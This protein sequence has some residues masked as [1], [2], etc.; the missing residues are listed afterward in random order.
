MSESVGEKT[1]I[2]LGP[3]FGWFLSRME[4]G[5]GRIQH[6]AMIG[7]VY[8]IAEHFSDA[9]V[10][11]LMNKL[12]VDMICEMPKFD[13]KSTVMAGLL[14][15]ALVMTILAAEIRISAIEVCTYFKDCDGVS[16]AVANATS[17][18]GTSS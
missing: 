18:N 10:M 12:R 4:V 13:A 11:W 15:A 14:M 3:V 9:G 8:F 6:L 17:L 2:I 7:I 1:L 16:Q 5:G